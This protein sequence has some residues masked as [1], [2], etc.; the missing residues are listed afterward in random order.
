M[1]LI[2]ILAYGGG[3]ILY[4]YIKSKYQGKSDV[5]HI[6]NYQRLPIEQKIFIAEGLFITSYFMIF[7]WIGRIYNYVFETGNSILPEIK[8][9]NKSNNIGTYK[10]L[11]NSVTPGYSYAISFWVYLNSNQQTVHS[12]QNILSYGTNPIIQYVPDKNQILIRSKNG[13]ITRTLGTIS[14][15]ALQKWN[16]VVLNYVNGTL[17]VFYNDKIVVSGEIIVPYL[18]DDIL[19]IGSDENLHGN[20]AVVIYFDHSVNRKQIQKIYRLNHPRFL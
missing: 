11:H 14:D 18:S 10:S 5:G 12:N 1:L 7:P 13:N 4:E 8:S 19:T 2:F 9:L 16:H 15:I 20:I 3:T 6:V 17:D